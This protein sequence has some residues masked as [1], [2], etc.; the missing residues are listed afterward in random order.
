M[1]ICI[2]NTGYITHL[3]LYVGK[4]C[5]RRYPFFLFCCLLL[6]LWSL[7][8]SHRMS[9]IVC[10]SSYKCLL[11]CYRYNVSFSFPTILQRFS[12]KTRYSLN[13]KS[14]PYHSFP[15][16]SPFSQGGYLEHLPQQISMSLMSWD[17]ILIMKGH[18]RF[19]SCPQQ[20]HYA[21]T[22]PFWVLHFLCF[23]SHFL[24]QSIVDSFWCDCLKMDSCR[25]AS[26]NTKFE[27][28]K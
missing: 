10:E 27:K 3:R 4:T 16:P 14:V 9:M 26:W 5:F 17:K 2:L 18:V 23:L 19:L 13:R 7:I 21:L 28:Y 12:S 20:L 8:T 15:C 1:H 11:Q 22:C 25:S 24:D 6:V